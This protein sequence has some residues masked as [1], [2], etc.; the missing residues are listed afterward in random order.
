MWPQKNV[1]T[2]ESTCSDLAHA[3]LGSGRVLHR[4]DQSGD[5]RKDCQCDL[6]TTSCVAR[7][8]MHMAL[9]HF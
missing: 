2:E 5:A 3:R 8:T 6:H 4:A 9:T 1:R 7:P